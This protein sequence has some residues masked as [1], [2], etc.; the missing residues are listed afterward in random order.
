MEV[1]VRFLG[2]DPRSEVDSQA[3]ALCQ[4]GEKSQGSF[5]RVTTA[6]RAHY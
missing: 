5:G 6:H 2:A 1:G 4:S 3:P